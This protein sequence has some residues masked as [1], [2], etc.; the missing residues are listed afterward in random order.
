MK[1]VQMEFSDEEMEILQA[2]SKYDVAEKMNIGISTAEKLKWCIN[3]GDV[4]ESAPPSEEDEFLDKY[5]EREGK[6]KQRLQDN[7]RISRKHIREKNRNENALTA[8]NESL[9]EIL[10][11]NPPTKWTRKLGSPLPDAEGVGV[12][13]LSDLHMNELVELTNNRFDF[14]VA[15]KRLQYL[16]K[17]AKKRFKDENV[18]NVLIVGTGDWI[19]SDRRIDE[20]LNMATNRTKAMLLTVM[21]IEQFILDIAT[22]FSVEFASITGN[23]SRVRDKHAYGDMV[24]TDNYD[25]SIHQTLKLL[26][27]ENDRVQFIDMDDPREGIINVCGHNLMILHGDTIGQNTI[28]KRVSQIKSKIASK[29]G[30]IVDYV[31]WGHIHSAYCSE[32]FSRS[33]SLVGANNFSDDALALESKA[34]Q[35]IYIFKKNYIEPTMIDL[36]DPVDVEGYNIDDTLKAYNTKSAQKAIKYNIHKSDIN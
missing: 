1:K 35:N 3:N 24:C 31:I 27:R 25:Y 28:H 2:Y 15:S 12:I 26:F 9:K 33:G 36:Q 30:I 16:A 17:R 10:S 7:L 18:T 5:I 19:N 34:S 6:S 4:V 14:D 32:T 29:Y 21:L 23:E 22:D 20:I 13:Q 11:T 8:L